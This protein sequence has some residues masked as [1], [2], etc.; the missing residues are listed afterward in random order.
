MTKGSYRDRKYLSFHSMRHVQPVASVLHAFNRQLEHVNVDMPWQI[1]EEFS[2]EE[3]E[4]WGLGTSQES[5]SE[6]LIPSSARPTPANDCKDDSTLHLALDASLET[7]HTSYR[8]LGAGHPMWSKLWTFEAPSSKFKFKSHPNLIYPSFFRT[9][10]WLLENVWVAVVWVHMEE[11]DPE[12]AFRKPNDP[13]IY[14]HR[15]KGLHYRFLFQSLLMS[16]DFH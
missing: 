2:E 12:K 5:D 1:Y 7:T 16:D 10:F 8:W 14:Y 11:G 9:D 4:I 6:G 13:D 15:G 3:S